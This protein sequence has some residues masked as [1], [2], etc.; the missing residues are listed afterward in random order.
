MS[1][2]ERAFIALGSNLGDRAA[3]LDDAIAAL[4]LDAGEV[5]AVSSR[6]ETP[7]LLPPDAPP[8]WNVPFL[9]QVIAIHTGLGP[10][11][12]LAT[13][14]AIEERLGREPAARWAPRRI[15]IDIL[16]IGDRV[17]DEPGLEVPH[18]ELHRRAFVL[19]PWAEIA[20]GWRHPVRGET[21]AE[22]RAAVQAGT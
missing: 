22:M 7:A 8:S 10:G 6:H 14:K 20:P 1:R 2:A 11:D 19:D 5:T 18:P 3:A 12:L 21:V 15:D 16:A 4:A 9:N 13:A 17:I